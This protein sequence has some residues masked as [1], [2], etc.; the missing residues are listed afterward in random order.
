M[1][2]ISAGLKLPVTGKSR[3]TPFVEGEDLFACRSS[4]DRAQSL[5][6]GPSEMGRGVGGDQDARPS[7]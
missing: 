5:S 6:L 1:F 3:F 7:S 4:R 2:I